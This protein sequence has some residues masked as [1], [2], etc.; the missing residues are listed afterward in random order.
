MRVLI[1]S[2]N[3]GEG[4][5]SAAKAIAEIFAKHGVDYEIKDA[6]LCFSKEISELVCKGHVM[7]YKRIPK[8]FGAGYKIIE[9]HAPEPGEHS[10]MFK[11]LA[12][13]G[14]K[15][16]KMVKEGEYTSVISVHPFASIMITRAI[17][18]YQLRV[19]SYFVATDYTC[20][21]GVA[22][23]KATKM[24][25]PHADIIPEFLELGVEEDKLI[26]SGI[27]VRQALYGEKDRAAAREQLDLPQDKTIVLLACG[28]MGCGP[29]KN[30]AKRLI[31][32]CPEDTM[33][34]SICGTNKKLYGK[35]MTIAVDSDRIRVIGFTDSMHLY[36]D[37]ADMTVTKPGGLSSTEAATKGL[38]MIFVDAVPGCETYNL[39]F[40]VRNGFAETADSV[41]G[42]VELVRRYSEDESLRSE[43]EERLRANFSQNAAEIICDRVER[44]AADANHV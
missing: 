18:V 28:S 44:D 21:P 27:P 42:L 29:I 15:L 5:N 6:L 8:V 33:I 11:L 31:E 37:A 43:M 1:L 36:M 17:D 41:E 20:S 13:G 16:Y 2:C 4:H 26:P 22:E 3:T 19:N 35:M 32:E 34:V 7:I 38:P 25:I 14:K 40:F 12:K 23:C 39:N 24:F 10:A 30:L 9:H